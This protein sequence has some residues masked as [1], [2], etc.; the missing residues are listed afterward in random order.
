MTCRSCTEPSDKQLAAKRHF[1]HAPPPNQDLHFSERAF[2]MFSTGHRLGD[3]RRLV[4]QYERNADSVLPWGDYHRGGTY[5]S[6]VNLPI[7]IAE[8]FNPNFD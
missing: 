2:W 5:G 8:A 7:P 4:R 1:F 3:L 6:D